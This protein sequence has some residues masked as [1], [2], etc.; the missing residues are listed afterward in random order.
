MTASRTR[1]I[2][3]KWDVLVTPGIP[4]VMALVG[5]FA[6]AAI[7]GYGTGTRLEYL[8]VPLVFGLG[9][10]LVA[11]GH[12][13]A[14]VLDGASTTTMD[15]TGGTIGVVETATMSTREKAL[16]LN[17]DA[18]TCGTFAGIGAGQEV[19]RRFFSAGGAAGTVAKSVS[20]YDM[21]VS[22]ARDSHDAP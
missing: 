4:M 7:A 17:L 2:P 11:M 6:A 15:T 13:W 10:P 20:A 9:A 12:C 1:G 18:T 16:A 3:L 21:A 19:A 8:L 22:A 14:W 5:K